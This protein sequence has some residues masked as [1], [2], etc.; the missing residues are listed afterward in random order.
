[1]YSSRAGIRLT[2]PLDLAATLAR[3]LLPRVAAPG[4]WRATRT[5][6]GPGTERLWLEGD[7]LRVEAWGA[8]A[9]WLCEH[10]S[11]L[12]GEDREELPFAEHPPGRR[13]VAGEHANL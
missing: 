13:E 10:A 2:R 7:V 9:D 4:A 8:G 6:A 11:A 12:V 5:P 1:M 3:A